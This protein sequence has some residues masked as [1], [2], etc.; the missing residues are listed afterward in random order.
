[1]NILTRLGWFIVLTL[2]GLIAALVWF[3]LLKGEAEP[4]M[5]PTAAGTPAPAQPVTI[6]TGS[7]TANAGAAAAT[8]SARRTILVAPGTRAQMQEQM[9]AILAAS[10]AV[11]EYA[12][13][14]DFS[15]ARN[16]A[17]AQGIA[18]LPTDPAMTG[19]LPSDYQAR[20]RAL[21]R[22][23]DDLADF[24]EANPDTTRIINEVTAMSIEC[25]ACHDAYR[26]EE[27]GAQPGVAQE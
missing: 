19:G 6:A 23:F 13:D 2:A 21:R 7:N 25:T 26:L 9:R 10:R 18:A 17:R 3:F 5:E 11:M 15:T 12:I 8:G 16:L 24:I 27:Q 14:E 20:T 22:S 4:A 1:M